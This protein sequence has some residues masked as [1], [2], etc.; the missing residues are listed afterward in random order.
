MTVVRPRTQAAQF[1]EQHKEP[2]GIQGLDVILDM[3]GRNGIFEALKDGMI[4]HTIFSAHSIMIVE[5]HAASK[6]FITQ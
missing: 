1:W 6:R 5:I 3:R 4:I 2:I